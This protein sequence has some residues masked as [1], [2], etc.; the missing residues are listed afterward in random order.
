W[1]LSPEKS[2]RPFARLREPNRIQEAALFVPQPVRS[3]ILQWAHTARFSCH[4]GIHRT[5][6]FLQRYFWWPTL[7]RDAKEYVSACTTCARN[8]IPNQPPSGSLHP[9]P[10]PT[11]P[12]SH[13]SLDFVTGLPPSAGNTV[14]LT[15]IDRFSKAAHFVAL[16]KLP[17][18]LE[19]ARLLTT[20]VFRLHGIPD[21]I[22]SDR[23]PQF[24]SRVWREFCTSLG[25]KVSLSS[26]YHPQSNGQSERVNQELEAALRC[27]VSS[28]QAVWSEELP[29][30]EY[31]HNS[32]TSSATGRSP[33]EASLGFQPPLFP[34]IE[35]EHSVP[36]VR[37]HLRRCRRVWKATR[38]AF[39]RTKDRNKRFADRRRSSAPAYTVG[40]KVWLSTRFVPIRAESRKLSPAYIGPFEI[41]ALVN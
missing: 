23:G 27:V 19:T 4:P 33:F 20:H 28:N 39:L 1:G 13:V 7:S 21:D 12:W 29:W 17:T 22:V 25:S 5:I 18:A 41:S 35:G 8:K 32:M 2:S 40:Q 31:A 14:I 11:R 37:A 9:L 36:S 10:T 15:I 24:T 6:T 16:P 30:I 38:A 34:S 3:Q 26:G